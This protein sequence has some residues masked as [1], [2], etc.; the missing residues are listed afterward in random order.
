VASERLEF[1]HSHLPG[2]CNTL[3]DA[4]SRNFVVADGASIRRLLQQ[5]RLFPLSAPLHSA[6]LA[7]CR[8]QSVVSWPPLPI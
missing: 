4:A 7:Q 2:R 5:G 3:A 6:T 8:T 1:S